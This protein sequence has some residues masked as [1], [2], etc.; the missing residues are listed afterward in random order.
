MIDKRSESRFMCADLVTIRIQDDAGAREEIANLED[1][2][3]SGACVQLEAATVA[4]ADIE[5][6][7]AKC[8]LKGKVRYC[9]F[10]QTGYDVGIAFDKPGSWNLQRFRPKHLLDMKIVKVD[11]TNEG[12]SGGGTYEG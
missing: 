5:M 9:R 6:V 2:S 11:A 12:P 3:A 7:C 8:S 10:A 4:G 1:I